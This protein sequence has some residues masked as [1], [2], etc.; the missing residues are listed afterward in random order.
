MEKA[1]VTVKFKG[2][3][4]EREEDRRRGPT[5][6]PPPLSDAAS[7]SSPPSPRPRPALRTRAFTTGSLWEILSQAR[8]APS[9]AAIPTSWL[10][11]AGQSTV[12]PADMARPVAPHSR[13]ITD[14]VHMERR[15]RRRHWSEFDAAGSASPKGAS[16]SPSPSSSIADIKS[17]ASSSSSG[18][19]GF[20]KP[21]NA[22]SRYP[23]AR[24]RE[25]QMRLDPR[26]GGASSSSKER[27]RNRNSLLASAYMS[28]SLTCLSPGKRRHHSCPSS[29]ADAAL[30]VYTDDDADTQG[31]PTYWRTPPSLYPGGMSFLGDSMRSISIY[32]KS[33][34][35]STGSADDEPGG[36]GCGGC[37]T[38]SG[39]FNVSSGSS[40]SVPSYRIAVIG[41]TDEFRVRLVDLFVGLGD[42]DVDDD[43]VFAG[44]FGLVLS[45]PM[46]ILFSFFYTQI[47]CTRHK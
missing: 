37:L 25:V 40:V 22:R 16:F 42:A 26:L 8:S 20:L 33:S 14:Y 19:D 28:T 12:S 9:R 30:S 24:S 2:V 6:L 46:S 39:T 41:A 3:P 27:N 15:H 10:T 31:M 13:L 4:E 43:D 23:G 7:T 47:M 35:N 38:P 29:D 1:A 45:C 5:F 32:R 18:T 34:V 11:S 17:T 44:E 21:E 36:G